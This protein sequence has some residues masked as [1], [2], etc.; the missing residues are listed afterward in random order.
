MTDLDLRSN[1]DTLVICLKNPEVREKIEA[2]FQIKCLRMT[3][4][5]QVILEAA[6]A[7]QGDHFTAEELFEKARKI[8]TKASLATLYRTVSLLVEGGLLHEIDLG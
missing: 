5:R 1:I 4:P 6:F 7:D 2:L 3:K 8:D